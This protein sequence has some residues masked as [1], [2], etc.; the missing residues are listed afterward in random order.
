[1]GTTN[2]RAKARP[3]FWQRV[4]G[5]YRAWRG[6]SV[7]GDEWGYP[8][9]PLDIFD[10]QKG[11]EHTFW[12][13]LSAWRRRCGPGAQ[14]RPQQQA[15][16]DGHVRD[17][18]R[19]LEKYNPFAQAIFSA[20]RSYV[21]GEQGLTA[22]VTVRPGVAPGVGDDGLQ[23]AAQDYLDGVMDRDDWWSRERELYVRCHRDGE[24][25]L[26][27]FAGKDGVRMRFIEPECVVAPDAT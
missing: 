13:M 9:S 14:Q 26:R 5:A 15:V 18:A 16:S 24:G 20:L 1:M 6:E 25:I 27:F 22:E 23:R 10:G 3:T 19:L 4:K 7:A 21:L 17:L 12:G 11:I 2:G 8:V